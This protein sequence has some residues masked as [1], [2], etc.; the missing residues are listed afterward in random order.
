MQALPFAAPTGSAAHLT[1]QML[2]GARLQRIAQARSEFFE[3]GVRPTGLVPESVIHSW[4]RCNARGH[5]THESLQFNPVTTSR[6]SATLDRNQE[7]LS[8]AREDRVFME[9]ALGGLECRV[10][11]TDDRGVI[12]YGTQNHLTS[13]EPV[14]RKGCRVGVKIGE[15]CLGTSAPAI[16]ISTGLPCTVTGAEHYFEGLHSLDCAAVPIRNVHGQLAGVLGIVAE[17]R[18]FSFDVASVAQGYA[19]SIENRLLKAQ[20]QEHIILSFQAH[21]QLLS[22]PT[23][24]LAGIDCHGDVKW[25]NAAAAR[26]LGVAAYSPDRDLESLFGMGLEAL[27]VMT[28]RADVTPVRLP[29]GLGI[30]AKAEQQFPDG[31]PR[32]QAT[33]RAT[34]AGADPRHS[35]IQNPAE[36]RDG[37]DV[38]QP[39]PHVLVELPIDKGRTLSRTRLSEQYQ[40]IIDNAVAACGGN[41]SL[42]ARTLGV[43]R[44]LVYR[45]FN[46]KSSL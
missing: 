40:K 25:L 17:G 19:V 4:M 33:R 3:N 15:G 7:L 14:L 39:E 37:N 38:P 46:S 27:L 6:L 22:G 18:R 43:S 36:A 32:S 5:K 24:A 42:A 45:H 1:T 35:K 16:T 31:L 20:S 41:I 34:T 11:L 8:A 21:P 30:W 28:R 2:L 9:A 26:L 12:V 44:G 29:S 13:Q 23:E 10:L